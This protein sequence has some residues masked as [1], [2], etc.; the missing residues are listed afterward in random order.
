LF[1]VA[2]GWS[3]LSRSV[4]NRRLQIPT[5]KASPYGLVLGK[6][7]PWAMLVASNGFMILAW[8]GHLKNRVL[9]LPLAILGSWLIALPE[10]ML[11]APANRIGRG[12]YSTAPLK[13]VEPRAEKWRPVFRKNDAK[14]KA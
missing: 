14:T 1:G 10:Y 8:Y 6:L 7:A 11:V 3:S 5:S 9:A 2:G 12:V 13:T 4:Y